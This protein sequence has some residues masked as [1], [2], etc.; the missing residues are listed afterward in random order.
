MNDKYNV[1][2]RLLGC[3]ERILVHRYQRFEGPSS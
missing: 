2:K 3:D 1:N